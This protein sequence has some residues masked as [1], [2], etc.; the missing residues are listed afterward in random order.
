LN[1]KSSKKAKVLTSLLVFI[2]IFGFFLNFYVEAAKVSR[3][4]IQ[5]TAP[6]NLKAIL[7][8]EN[9][10]SM[11]WTASTDNVRVSAYNIYR[12]STYIGYTTTTTYTASGL[13]SGITYNFTVKAK[14]VAGNL[15][16][17]SNILTVATTHILPPLP[18]SVKKIVGYYAGWSAYSGFTPD[19]IDASKLTHI[20]Y[21]FANI[22]SDLKIAMGDSYVD[23]NNFSK[24]T[25][26]KQQYPNLKTLISVGGWDWSG[27][28]SNVAFTDESRTVFADSC[29]QFILQY[30]FDGVD[31]D[32]E[33]PVNGGLST[34][35]RRAGD[36]QNFTLL[37]QKLREKLDAQGSIDGKSYL[38]T[39]SG[40]ANASYL[41]NTE[42]TL[43]AKYVDYAN[44]M[45]YDI[46][47]SWDSYTDFNAPLYNNTD[48]SPQYKWSAD[49]AVNAWVNAG[50]PIGKLVMGVPFY[51]YKYASVNNANNGL[52]QTFTGAS[53]I[54]YA[55]IA[56][57]Y[58]NNV[59]STE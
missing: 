33:Y 59:S 35:V 40:A 36:K 37:M 16:Y 8:T 26:L 28:F 52:Y 41:N 49:S 10:V 42:P 1:R 44:I 22:G 3:D 43:L 53:S 9:S 55:G 2:L 51:G 32:W 54:S 5:P 15:S 7:V 48:S 45:T 57:N 21:A 56:A 4:R 13:A 24:L 27:K 11:T 30:G 17:V 18:S 39:Y 19:K 29:V 50:F 31:I 25:N 14:D 58:L 20:N 38:L 12:N 47:G 34:N 23:P 6:K 46:H